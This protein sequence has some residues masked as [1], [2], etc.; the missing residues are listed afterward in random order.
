[1]PAQATTTAPAIL[2]VSELTKVFGA[3]RGATVAVDHI[4][5]AVASGEIIALIGESGSGKT[6]TGRMLLG[7]M[8]PS[9]GRIDYEG[10]DLAVLRRRF[11]LRA[12]WRN[13]QAIFQDPF[14]SFNGFYSIRRSM[15]NAFKLLPQRPSHKAQLERIC[16]AIETVGLDVKDVLSKYPHQ[17]SGGQRQRLMIARALVIQPKVL[18]ADEPTSMIDASSRAAILNILLKLRSD[19]GMSIIFITHDIGMAYYTSDRLLIMC[20]GRIVE[21]GL[22]EAVISRPQHPY[23]QRLLADVPTLHHDWIERERA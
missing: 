4:S 9:A 7:L 17:L 2:S 8:L 18:I 19:F 5:F 14:S 22:A 23:T 6:T 13:V 21:E 3:G 20:Q 12:Y 10:T 11:G 1:V 16:T 15:M